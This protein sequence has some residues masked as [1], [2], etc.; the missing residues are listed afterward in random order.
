MGCRRNAY[1]LLMGEP[2]GK[3]LQGGP[4]YRWVDNIRMGFG[5][6]GWDGVY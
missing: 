3:R 5:E 4:R 2:E 1:K 6:I